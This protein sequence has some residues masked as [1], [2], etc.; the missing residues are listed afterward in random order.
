MAFNTKVFI[1]ILAAILIVA[2]IVIY[3]SGGFRALS[4]SSETPATYNSEYNNYRQ[5]ESVLDDKG[6]D[7]SAN[8]NKKQ[9][10]LLLPIRLLN[11]S[12]TTVLPSIFADTINQVPNNVNQNDEFNDASVPDDLA[13]SKWLD[14]Y[15]PHY[16]K[17]GED[18]AKQSDSDRLELEKRKQIFLS[19]RNYII[20]FNK[21]KSISFKLKLNHFG[22]LTT[23]EINAQYI[24]DIRDKQEIFG[25]Q[26]RSPPPVNKVTGSPDEESIDWS[27]KGVVYP[28]QNQGKCHSGQIHAI[29][30]AT[31]P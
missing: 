18:M 19:N 13:W 31:S 1:A 29:V 28:A 12:T 14:R 24:G 16:C 10:S 15:R 8:A 3:Q 2:T 9:S 21:Q 25:N 26:H 5:P 27:K 23:D 11:L 7:K 22:D 20:A 4:S 6:A 17:Y 30:S